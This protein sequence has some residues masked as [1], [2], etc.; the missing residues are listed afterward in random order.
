MIKQ[1]HANL[2]DRNSLQYAYQNYLGDD[3]GK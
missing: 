1:T 2:G 3:L